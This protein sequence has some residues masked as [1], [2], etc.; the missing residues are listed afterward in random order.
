M[1]EIHKNLICY[2]CFKQNGLF[3][4]CLFISVVLHYNVSH[5][6]LSLILGDTESPLNSLSLVLMSWNVITG[7][8]GNDEAQELHG[9][10]TGNETVSTSEH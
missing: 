7:Q 9:Q 5:T 6:V 4:V 1:L 10:F 3:W 2:G 8:E